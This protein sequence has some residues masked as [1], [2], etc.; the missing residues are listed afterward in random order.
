MVAK[1]TGI[2]RFLTLLLL[3]TCWV[4]RP[5]RAEG[6]T[7]ITD[8]ETQKFLA[9][10]V[11]PLYKAAGIAFRPDHIYIVRDNSLNAFVSEGNNMFVHTGT[12]LEADNVNELSGIL[13]HETGHIMGGH[14]V[15][16]QLKI[17]KMRYVML[18]SMIAAGAAAVSTGRGDAAMAIML[19]S[20]SSA[21]NSLLHYQTQEERS[22]DESAVKLL[23]QTHQST[24]GLQNFMSKIRKRNA[25]SG[26]SESPYFR[27]HPMTS[28]RISHF[29]EAGKNNHYPTAHK[30]DG[31]FLMIKAKL[32]AFLLDKQKVMRLYPQS[33]NSPAGRYARSILAYRSSNMN[34]ALKLIDGLIAEQ[35]QNPYF[36]ELKGQFL[37]ES[38]QV[39]KSISA[40]ETAL[41]LRPDNAIL[42]TYL[43]Q[44]MLEN[45]PNKEQLQRIILLLQQA[46]IKIPTA[47]GWQ[48]LSRAYDM[49]ERR[50]DSLYAA[51]EFSYEIDNLEVAQKQLENARKAG[52][53]K[54]LS[55]K[56]SD[57][58]QRIKQELKERDF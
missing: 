11:G 22:A 52:A 50:A 29:A 42:K 26:V 12:L 21:L 37:F 36:Y 53:D 30:L 41:R 20:Q 28:E 33:D 40:Y 47:T 23:A 34:E 24:V 49:S 54:S 38:G 17:Q 1:I 9:D 19:G 3:I 5:V 2:I 35:P 4:C 16:Q 13:A 18:G 51:A 8:A 57:L 56:I 7:L 46:Q 14:I 25:L 39:G 32:A 43:A 45:N 6:I 15:R 44:A 31:E 58:E 48:L 10:I 27:T 55:L